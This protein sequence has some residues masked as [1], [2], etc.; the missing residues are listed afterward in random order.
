MMPSILLNPG[1]EKTIL[2]R[3]PWIFSGALKSVNGNPEPGATVEVRSA[4]DTLLG[5]AAWSPESQ[6]CGRVWSFDPAEAIDADFFRRKIRRAIAL[7]NEL[8]LNAADGGCRLVASEADGLPGVIADRYGDFAVIQLLSAGAEFHKN[9]IAGILLEESGCRGVYERSDVA[10]RAREGLAE[11]TGLLAGEEPP[12]LI[13]IVENGV[14]YEVDVRQGH[15]TGFYLDQRANRAA[16]AGYAAG[17]EVL[18]CFAYTGG[19]AVAA[20]AA[21]AK[22]AVNVDSSAPALAA[23]ARNFELNGIDPERYTNITA[24]VFSELRKFRD[25]ART[26]D[27]IVLDPPKFVDSKNAL[28]RGCRAYQDI[29]RLAFLL[30]RPGGMLFTFSCSGLLSAE[31][32]QKVTADAALDAG[33]EAVIVG[34]LEQAPD[35]PTSL[36]VPESFYLKGLAVKKVF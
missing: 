3:H 12:A 8:G 15:K 24:D 34:R 11:C 23:A 14:R 5:H 16:V 22:H 29:A 32:F 27:L 20:L 21:G 31:L 7:R 18:N 13:T 28:M 36:A 33:S 4:D 35:H 19:F 30:L 1:R 10:I 25:R 6:I 2:R 17:K 26:F 9:T